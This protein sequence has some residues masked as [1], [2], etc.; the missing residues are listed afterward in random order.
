[1]NARRSGFTLIE[2]A[3]AVVI[4]GL[5]GFALMGIASRCLAVAHATRNY[6]TAASVLDAAELEFPLLPT[7]P[8]MDNVVSA[9]TYE[10]HFVF[11]RDVEPAN[12]EEDLFV[13]RS[14]VAWPGRGGREVHEDVERFLF[15][16]NHP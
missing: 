15:T 2:A 3:F 10:D 13:I 9:H 14:R 11:T 8:V 6:H 1:M 4:M 12:G 7:N 16:T 5:C